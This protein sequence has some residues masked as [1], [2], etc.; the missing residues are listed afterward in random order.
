LKNA[1]KTNPK[2]PSRQRW[3]RGDRG[4]SVFVSPAPGGSNFASK[5]MTIGVAL[6]HVLGAHVV[7]KQSN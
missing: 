3:E 5:D 4:V 2:N 1:A 7:K 6:L